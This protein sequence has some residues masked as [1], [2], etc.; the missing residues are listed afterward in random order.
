MCFLDGERLQF[1]QLKLSGL[2]ENFPQYIHAYSIFAML[3][4]LL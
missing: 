3:F 4:P 1:D 2:S